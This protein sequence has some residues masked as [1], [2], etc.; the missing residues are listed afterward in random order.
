MDSMLTVYS[1]LHLKNQ[2]AIMHTY[3][4]IY[5]YLVLIQCVLIQHTYRLYGTGYRPLFVF[6]IS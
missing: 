5:I 1:Y 4:V 2:Q 6:K 3:N